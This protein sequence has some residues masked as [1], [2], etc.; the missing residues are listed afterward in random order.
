MTGSNKSFATYFRYYTKARQ[1][2][3]QYQHIPS[4]V[5]IHKECL[6]IVKQLRLI[7]LQQFREKEVS[8]EIYIY[9]YLEIFIKNQQK[10]ADKNI[11]TG[12]MYILMQ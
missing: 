7:L 1:V 9:Y 11:N 8:C 3:D 5:G 10:Q 2:L 6:E 12:K 4:F